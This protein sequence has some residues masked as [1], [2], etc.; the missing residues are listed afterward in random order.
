MITGKERGIVASMSYEAKERGVTRAMR[1]SEVKKLCPDAVMLPSD[2]ETYSLLSKR[3]FNIVRR[4]TPEVE[5]YSIDECLA[6]LTGL[7]RP[8]RLS[9]ARIAEKIKQSLDA[10]LGF[11]FSVGLAPNKVIAKI[12]S[13]WSKPSGLT[14]IPAIAIHQYLEKLPV[15]KVWGI[16]SQ[17]TA[18]L[19]KHGITTALQFARKS[20]EW[21]KKYFTKPHYEIWQELNGQYIKKLDSK[22]KDTYYLIQKFQNVSPPSKDEA[23]VFAQLCKN[24]EN[25]TIKARK[26]R[27]AARGGIIILRTQGFRD[28]GIEIK[29]SSPTS[30]PNEVIDA[31]R[32]AFKMIFNAQELYRSTGIMLFGLEGQDYS[33]LDLFG[34]MA[35]RKKLVHLYERVDAVRERY[36]KHTLFLGASFQAHKFAQHIGERGDAPERKN[37]LFKGETKRRRLAI[38]TFLGQVS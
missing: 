24:I 30:I 20:E 7:Q 37:M 33:Q 12:A 16:G 17:S 25:A 32:P 27:L 38:P 1:L 28:Y 34:T 15:E 31:I 13:K 4:F 18:F 2:Y 5:E 21:I 19:A 6:D 29:F 9:Y 14:I 26:H 3:F 22:P 23:F 8:L 11:T 10:E 36:G 35:K